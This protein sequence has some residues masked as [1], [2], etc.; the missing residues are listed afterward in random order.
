MGTINV[1]RYDKNNTRKEVAYIKCFIKKKRN[2]TIF[3]LHKTYQR[4]IFKEMR[5]IVRNMERDRPVSSKQ[6]L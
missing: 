4:Y 1:L 2:V 6:G 5:R 3:Y